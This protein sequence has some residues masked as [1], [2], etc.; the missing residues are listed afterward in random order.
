MAENENSKESSEPPSTKGFIQRILEYTRWGRSPDTKEALEMEIQELLEEGEE[1]GLIGSMEEKMISSIFEFRETLAVEI[2]TPAAEVVSLEVSTPIAEITATIIEEGFTRIP[3][4]Q[5]NPDRI[6][7]ILHAKDLLRISSIPEGE[8]PDLLAYLKPAEFIRENKPIV[9]L[10]REFQKYQTHMAMVTDEFGTMRG[11]ITLED[12]LE[13]IVGEI[14]D[15]YDTSEVDIEVI[16][17]NTIRARAKID[18]EE[19]EEQFQLELPEGPYESVG[20][21]I[22]HSLGRIGRIG[23]TLDVGGLRFSIK[24]ATR[25]SINIVEISRLEPEQTEQ[26]A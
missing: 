11:L 6:I 7:G 9:E 12:I 8:E 17:D 10:L 4:Y 25:R 26:Q 19:V 21:L 20:G 2:M 22:I 23:D 16:D 15:E 24:S 5:E 1:Q 3:I 14:D 13:E 18:I